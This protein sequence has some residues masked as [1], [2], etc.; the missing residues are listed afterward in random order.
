[1][2][3]IVPKKNR[4]TPESLLESA[5]DKLADTFEPEKGLE[6][7]RVPKRPFP[8]GHVIDVFYGDDTDPLEVWYHGPGEPLLTMSWDGGPGGS[9]AWSVSGLTLPSRRRVYV[10]S[11]EEETSVI[12]ASPITFVPEDLDI[13]LIELL[14]RDNGHAFGVGLVGSLPGRISFGVPLGSRRRL[15]TVTTLLEAAGAMDELFE[16]YG[17]KKSNPQ[18]AVKRWLSTVCG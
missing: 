18:A 16:H 13:R 3:R 6:P 4:A 12:A 1:M 2:A 14:A 10:T 8:L 5:L 9:S 17:G 11:L 15:E 7:F